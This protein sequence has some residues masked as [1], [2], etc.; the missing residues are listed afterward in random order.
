M[1]GSAALAVR[2]RADATGRFS[3]GA[4]AGDRLHETAYGLADHAG[5]AVKG[6]DD[7]D[8]A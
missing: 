3:V 8:K 1:I 6:I 7:S 5:V 4:Q 2:P